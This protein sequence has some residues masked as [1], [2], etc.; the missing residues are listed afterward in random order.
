MARQAT[1]NIETVDDL[2][3]APLFEVMKQLR[4]EDTVGITAEHANAYPGVAMGV[5]DG[6]GDAP[7]G[8]GSIEGVDAGAP[9]PEQASSAAVEGPLQPDVTHTKARE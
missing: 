1:K 5:A 4:P 2:M 8:K 3:M 7:L 6:A 9:M